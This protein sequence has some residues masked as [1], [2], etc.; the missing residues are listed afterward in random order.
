MKHE[1]KPKIR[2]LYYMAD[3]M[4]ELKSVSY[5]LIDL[6][7]YIITVSLWTYI[8]PIVICYL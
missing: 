7:Y 3:M 1:F 8:Q 2:K 5:L 6:G 4:Y